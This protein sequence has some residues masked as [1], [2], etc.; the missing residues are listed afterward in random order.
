MSIF[1][2]HNTIS[3]LVVF[4]I[5]CLYLGCEWVPTEV[6]TTE[7]IDKVAVA[8]I[9]AIDDNTLTGT[10]T[11]T[12]VDGSVH[13]RIEIQNVSPG[14]H[15]THLHLGN[16]SD[17]GPHWHPLGIPAGTVG[18]P[19]AEATLETPPIGVGEIGN[20]PVGE[21]GTGILEFTTP[22]WSIGGD[23]NSDILGKLILIHE[24]GDTF[25]THPHAQHSAMPHTDVNTE[26][27]TH[28]SAQM[29]TGMEITQT[30]HLCTLAV[31]GQQID[32]NADHHLPGQAVSPHSHD[33]LELLLT[34]FVSPEQL[35]NPAILPV[36]PL[37]GTPEHQAYLEIE[38]KSLA[39]YHEFF[40]AIGL[41]V[42]PDFFTN[43]YQQTFPTD[44][45]GEF[46]QEMRQR[47][48]HLYIASGVDIENLTDMVGYNLFLTN[49]LDARTTVWVLG[50]FQGDDAAFGEW[51]SEV[52]NAVQVRP[53]G[54]SRIGCGVIG[55]VE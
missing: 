16:C 12:Q 53:G 1:V 28:N 25:Q 31:L 6:I 19:V 52:L 43:Q 23:P 40:I 14:L 11:F 27:H 50:Y 10:A 2:R 37:Q 22:F 9:S 51:I 32:L 36:L 44:D 39:A 47:L 42:D 15:A 45:P 35:T 17:I 55:L 26:I 8:T 46:E 13:V 4:I 5:S 3:V 30:T 20:I 41:P 7:P 33:M 48:T 21:D 38:P 54:G 24:A 49:F 34:C 18:V 29:Q